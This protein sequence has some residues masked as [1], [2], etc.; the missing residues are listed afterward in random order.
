M[1]KRNQT[2]QRG[3]VRPDQTGRDGYSWRQPG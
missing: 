1:S 3:I 2:G